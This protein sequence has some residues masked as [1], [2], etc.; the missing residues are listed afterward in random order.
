VT[1]SLHVAQKR[2]A[3]ELLWVPVQ[4]AKE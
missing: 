1:H 2:G 4:A 3:P